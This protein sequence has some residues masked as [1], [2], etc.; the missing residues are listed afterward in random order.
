MALG[1]IGLSASAS[2][3]KTSQTKLMFRLSSKPAAPGKPRQHGMGC[4]KLAGFL[5]QLPAILVANIKPEAMADIAPDGSFQIVFRGQ[6][7]HASFALI[8]LPGQRTAPIIDVMLGAECREVAPLSNGGLV[9]R[10]RFKPRAAIGIAELHS[11]GEE[12]RT[13]FSGP[14]LLIAQSA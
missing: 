10:I 14:T 12:Q 1:Q 4:A 3:G 5:D 13:V 7:I 2:G 11:L 9:A 8:A 6:R